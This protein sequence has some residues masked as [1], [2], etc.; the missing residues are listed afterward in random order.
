VFLRY[1]KVTSWPITETK[2]KKL[3]NQFIRISVEIAANAPRFGRPEVGTFPLQLRPN[4]VEYEE[5][6]P[7]SVGRKTLGM[8]LFVGVL[9]KR[10]AFEF[11]SIPTGGRFMLIRFTKTQKKRNRAG[12]FGFL[13]T[14]R[15]YERC[16]KCPEGLPG[17]S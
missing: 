16:Q 8:L 14:L 10:T 7:H 4:G 3:S 17:L 12:T 2:K 1:Q 11:R 5:H 13:V 9:G 15:K 6:K